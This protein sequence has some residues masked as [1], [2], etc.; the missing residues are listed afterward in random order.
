M[1][2]VGNSPCRGEATKVTV[3]AAGIVQPEKMPPNTI[4]KKKNILV[5]AINN[6]MEKFL[7]VES[8]NFDLQ[9]FSEKMK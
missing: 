6:L 9:A 7:P 8:L 5:T 4:E 2:N 1:D 3:D